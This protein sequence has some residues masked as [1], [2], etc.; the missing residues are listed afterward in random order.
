MSN[1]AAASSA[2]TPS[3]AGQLLGRTFLHPLFDYAF[4]AGGLSVI[5]TALIALFGD[6]LPAM[7]PA[8]TLTTILLVNSCHFAASTV[9]LYTKPGAFAQHPFL[10]M[11]FPLVTLAVVTA[12]MLLPEQFGTHL[13]A[14]YLTWSPYH[15][16]AQAY[17]L[18]VMYAY[19]SGNTFTPGE[20][21]ALWN[22]AMFPFLGA[23]LSNGASGLS[24]FLPPALLEPY[25]ALVAIK[26]ALAQF[27]FILGYAAPLLLWASMFRRHG[28]A[29]PAL[30]ILPLFANALWWNALTYFNAFNWATVFHG[31]QYMAIIMIFHVRERTAMPDN[32]RGGL[33]HALWFYGA[34]LALGYALFQCLPRG[35][36]LMGFGA[37]ESVL[38]T[39]S[40]I[41]L[42][43]FIVDAYI[44]R[45]KRTDGNQKLVLRGVEP[46]AAATVAA[47]TG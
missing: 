37:A 17:G 34:C 24:W 3:L 12:C 19:R 4:I 42:H 23:F 11:A 13:T 21:R 28:R 26:A 6:P 14:L 1:P 31:L 29:L 44:W 45:L 33:H 18:G 30:C 39:V 2:A 36:E 41:N 46:S 27:F 25:P 7:S 20:K 10:T 22:V 38:I 16:A 32:K 9:R 47:A 43:H 35:F 15:Y 5:A 40:A 8:L